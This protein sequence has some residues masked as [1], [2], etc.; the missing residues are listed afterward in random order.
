M[1]PGFNVTYFDSSRIMFQEA[2]KSKNKYYRKYIDKATNGDLK[3]SIY[4]DVHGTGAHMIDFCK[5]EYKQIPACFLLTVG[6][7]SYKDLPK[8]CYAQYKKNRLKV[9]SLKKKGSPIEM[10]NYDTIGTLI[11]YNKTGPVRMEPEYSIDLLKPYHKCV[12]T[13]IKIHDRTP[14][15]DIDSAQVD[16]CFEFL[17]KRIESRK[18]Q[19]TINK[20]ITHVR[21]H[22]QDFKKHKQQV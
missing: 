13:F 10:L 8:E 7:D 17:G 19:P 1:F 20:W 14:E 11:D 2:I 18:Q 16:K 3:N 15:Y 5:N 21:K 6:A 9:C 4:V 12:E 22:E